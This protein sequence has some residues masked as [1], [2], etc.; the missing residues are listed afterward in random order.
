[1]TQRGYITILLKGDTGQNITTV[2]ITRTVKPLQGTTLEGYTHFVTWKHKPIP[3]RPNGP[4]YWWSEQPFI[5]HTRKV[6]RSGRQTCCA[7]CHTCG[8]HMRQVLDGEQWCSK[9]GT[10]R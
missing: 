5:A 3:V 4:G 1:M 10:Y 6:S 8:T 7:V 9:C 2:D